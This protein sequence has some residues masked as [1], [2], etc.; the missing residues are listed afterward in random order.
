MYQN[1]DSKAERIFRMLSEYCSLMEEYNYSYDENI[2]LDIEFRIAD[3]IADSFPSALYPFQD[4]GYAVH[5]MM[6][7]GDELDPHELE[8]DFIRLYNHILRMKDKRNS[9]NE[10]RRAEQPLRVDSLSRLI[11]EIDQSC[12]RENEYSSYEEDFNKK[13]FEKKVAIRNTLQYIRNSTKPVQRATLMAEIKHCTSAVIAYTCKHYDILNY[14]SAYFC[15]SHILLTQGEKEHFKASIE[16]VLG[17]CE[18]HHID[19]LYTKVRDKERVVLNKAFVSSSFQMMSLIRYLFR[20]EYNY[21]RP[22]ISAK[23]IHIPTI[24]ERVIRFI[25]K[26]NEIPIS[27]LVEFFRIKKIEIPRLLSLLDTINECVLIKD[28]STLVATNS[29]GLTPH[30]LEE[31]EEIIT[32][33]LEE[34]NYKAVRDLL[35][36]PQL[37]H[38]SIPWTEWLLYSV[39]RRSLPAIHT[40]TTSPQFRHGIPV[41]SLSEEITDDEMAEVAER[42]KGSIS[43]TVTADTDYFEDEIDDDLL[44]EFDWED[45]DEL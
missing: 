10:E 4:I 15:G 45:S 26:R 14:H 17:D 29:L 21:S 2:I 40:Y 25:N 18:I 38:I 19:E 43:T 9:F 42:H 31:I 33:E 5:R 36:F 24:P 34:A 6:D 8:D 7:S 22:F 27:E 1:Y 32:E 23:S 39:V 16:S 30:T 44:L 3:A 37:P 11:P 35:C 20:R 41:L 28:H 13:E 12:G